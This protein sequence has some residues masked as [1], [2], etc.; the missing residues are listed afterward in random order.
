[1][2]TQAPF[3]PYSQPKGTLVAGQTITVNKYTV[4]V[5]R[6]LSQGGFAHVYLV[7]TPTPVYNTTHHVLKRIA[8]SS[9]A[10]LTEVKK[11]VDVMRLLRGHPNIVYL[12]DAAWHKMSNG[13]YEV[14]ILMEYCPGGGIIDMMNRRLRERL[15][16]AE[17]LQIFVDVC[18]GVACM[19]NSRPPLLHR[20]LK[21]EN[22]LQSSPTSYKLCDFGSA[23]TVSRTPTSTQEIRALEADLN[24]HTTLQ[25]RA[26]EMIDVYSKR[27]IDEKSDVWALGVLLYKLCYYTT[28]FEEHGPLAILNVQ[29][30][31][32]AYPVYSSQMNLLIAS[33]LREH[34]AQ[35]P[36]VFELLAHVHRLRGTKSQF[37]YNIPVPQPLSPRH[38]LSPKSSL[39]SNP[40]E[41]TITY[42]SQ[43]SSTSPVNQ[44]VQ[45]RD[46]VLEAIAPMRRG[47]P[48]V[49]KDSR[50][51]SSR[52]SSP[53]KAVSSQLPLKEKPAITG[54]AMDE[55]N[56][57][58]AV[59]SRNA[60]TNRAGSGD[61]AWKVNV[62]KSRG[63]IM[64]REGSQRWNPT[65]IKPGLGAAVYKEK[66]AFAGLGLSIIDK[67]APTLG[68]ARKLRTGLAITSTS[69]HGNSGGYYGA[70]YGDKLQTPSSGNLTPLPQP[71]PQPS[72]QLQ[73]RP[74]PRLQHSPQPYSSS[75]NP[76]SSS[77]ASGFTGRI[78]LP[79]SPSSG[80]S[81]NVP[82][83]SRFP[84]LEEL[85]ATFPGS[86][87]NVSASTIAPAPTNITSSGTGGLL[88]IHNQNF[89]SHPHDG[90][91]RSAQVT[92]VAMR[93]SKLE[94]A[95][96]RYRNVGNSSSIGEG[97]GSGSAKDQG[98]LNNLHEV[99]SRMENSK[100]S[101]LPITSKVTSTDWLT[102]DDEH[103][104]AQTPQTSLGETPVLRE[105]PSKRASYIEKSDFVLQEPIVAQRGHLTSM[106]IEPPEIS[107][108]LS[109]FQ[110]AF[111]PIDVTESQKNEP[112]TE[113]WSP[114]AETHII[115]KS[116]TRKDAESSSSEE[117]IPEDPSRSAR[118]VL[119]PTAST[120]PQRKGRQ[121]SVHDLL[122]LFESNPVSKEKPRI[123]DL[124]KENKPLIQHSPTKR[125]SKL[126]ATI[127]TPQIS[128]S[129]SSPT[130]TKL[131]PLASVERRSLVK[132][133]QPTGRARPQSMFITPSK[134][135][136][137]VV[138]NLIPPVQPKPSMR[139]TSISDMVQ[140]YETIGNPTKSTLGLGPPSPAAHKTGFLLKTSSISDEK[141]SGGNEH[142]KQST[143]D[144][145][146]SAI[147][148]MRVT[149]RRTINATSKHTDLFKA[150][151]VRNPTLDVSPSEEVRSPSP[152]QPYQGVGKLI[153]QWQR[154][155]AEAAEMSRINVVA[156]KRGGIAPKRAGLVNGSNNR[157]G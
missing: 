91:A 109:R 130:Q 75:S 80:N 71:Q 146:A 8:V 115:S 122:D 13:T 88:K 2:A 58:K 64:E 93:Q 42:T 99:S 53:Q 125:D 142:D 83:E 105:S 141:R 32:P 65:P 70:R 68:E 129:I 123:P 86:S 137:K 98:T 36:S 134:G 108:T 150:S 59:V 18:E 49:T 89:S 147:S 34:G 20:D 103:Q 84:S 46:K 50:N 11:E 154:K 119:K 114:V 138:N 5:E 52:P 151:G 44:G 26:P 82:A 57:W 16:E 43:M 111:P 29:Y 95:S 31:T 124:P 7:R 62:D 30:R 69:F 112:L 136:E 39:V 79:A 126:V 81:G 102:G 77:S 40:L 143:T 63:E 51:D 22:I 139:R 48:Q 96:D 127:P 55:D 117:E 104:S 10:M 9:E 121:S 24:R 90:G 21:V 131:D 101:T 144:T 76:I 45:A 60:E 92:G 66:D 97:Y 28:P 156:S 118:N 155:T 132:T 74:S 87:Y 140:L 12:I 78:P 157:G 116:S 1:M 27:P 85:D 54:F 67:P 110:R 153:D 113:N 3:N 145:T 41:G 47:R 94:S 37:Q 23:A 148:Q 149:P 100:K 19:H 72:P 133:P 107:P 120:R 33:M 14:F 56:A 17:I 135:P 73:S 106:E 38:Q 61:D 35:R 4:Q 25:Y 6:Y 128:P 152:E 15:T